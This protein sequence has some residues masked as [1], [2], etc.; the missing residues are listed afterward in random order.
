MYVK[1]LT[2]IA[3]KLLYRTIAIITNVS[4]YLFGKCKYTKTC[5]FYEKN[6][7]NCRYQESKLSV[8]CGYRR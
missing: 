3:K 1:K 2:S 7:Y 8:T 6:N 4:A 5:A